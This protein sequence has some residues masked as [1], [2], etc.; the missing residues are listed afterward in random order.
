[1]YDLPGLGWD[2][3]W[4]AELAALG[5][6]LANPARV[7]GVDRGRIDLLGPEG[8]KSVWLAVASAGL[9]TPVVGDWVAYREADDGSPLLVGALTRRSLLVRRAAGREPV[10][11]PLAANVDFVLV[12]T[13]VGGDFSP[14]RVERYATAAWAGGARPVIV[15]SKVD[16]A[17][18]A[19]ALVRELHAAA[20]NASVFPVS[21][22]TGQGL[23]ALTALL[24]PGKTFVLVGSSGVGKSTLANRLLGAERFATGAIREHDET[25]RHTTTRRELVV[26]PSRAL[27][28]DTPGMREFGLWEAAEGLPS[29]F[30]EIEAVTARCRFRDCRHGNEPGC[31]VRAALQAG[32]ITAARFS[33]YVA[34]RAELERTTSAS[35]ER[36]NRHAPK[37]RKPEPRRTRGPA[38]F[39]R[40]PD[41]E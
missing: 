32:R 33:S 12:T 34:L 5:D 22:L 24:A 17:E 19:D 1:V 4:S 9:E 27:L 13:A 28:I 18:D 25:G 38:R 29:V 20:P 2:E 8:P 23:D 35:H 7:V 41:E 14:R 10:P 26:T 39:S 40:D 3:K 21:A 30:P 36:R 31:A 37:G 16:M 6:E 11:Q 15:L